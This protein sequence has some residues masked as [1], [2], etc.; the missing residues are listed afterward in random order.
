MEEKHSK[1]PLLYLFVALTASVCLAVTI[2]YLEIRRDAEVEQLRSEV[3][4]L[5]KYVDSLKAKLNRTESFAKKFDEVMGSSEEGWPDR[6][7]F[8]K[9]FRETHFYYFT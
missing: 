1:Q 6:E 4:I 9:T 8:A 3:A 7:W 2:A 5:L